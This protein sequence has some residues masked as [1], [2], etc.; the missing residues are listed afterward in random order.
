MGINAVHLSALSVSECMMHE[1]AIVSVPVP[2]ILSSRKR[3]S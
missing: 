1:R 2:S 3:P